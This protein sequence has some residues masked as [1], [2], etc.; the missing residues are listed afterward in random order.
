MSGTLAGPLR[1]LSHLYIRN[2]FY[3]LGIVVRFNTMTKKTRSLFVL[4]AFA[5][6]TL[7]TLATSPASPVKAAEPVESSAIYKITP[8]ESEAQPLGCVYNCPTLKTNTPTFAVQD[9]VANTVATA[10]EID[11]FNT[12]AWDQASQ[13]Q[14]TYQGGCAIVS[15]GLKCWGDNSRGQL[16]DETITS[17]LTTPVTATEG[18][19]ALSNVTDVSTN[20]LTTCVVAG[21]ALKCVGSGNWE[22]NYSKRHQMYSNTNTVTNGSTSRVNS[23]SQKLE[24]FNAANTLIYTKTDTNWIPDTLVSKNWTTFTAL[25]SNVAK[26][27]VGSGQNGSSTPT[28]CVLLTTGLA[29]CAVVTA[30]T[31]SQPTELN[32]SGTEYDCNAGSA[33]DGVYESTSWCNDAG[34]NFKSR[35]YGQ[36]GTLTG[37]ATWTWADAEVTGAVD[38]AMPADSW[39][40]S[41]ICFAGATT[42]CR[43]FQS[44]VFG[45][46]QTIENGENSQAVYMTSG[47]GP[48]G[49]CL[50]S[51]NTISCGAGTSGS[52]GVSAVAT[53]V[54]AVA[55]MAKPLNIFFGNTQLMQKLYFLLPTGLLAADAWILT[56]SGCQSQSG[57][58]VAPVTAFSASTSTAFTYAKSVNGATDSADYIPMTVMSG[59]RKSRSSVAISVKTAS[60]ENLTGVSVRWTAP[61]APGLLS[62]SASSTLA[63]DANGAA[64][65]TV[66]SGPVTF[67][68]SV[69]TVTVCPPVCMPGQQPSKET[70]PATPSTAGVLASGATLQAASITVIVG[71]TG[72]INI[73]VPDAPAIVARKIS[74]TLPDG[75]P[76]PN[77]TVQLK[78]NY[79]TYAYTNSG[80][81][82]S[83]W[84]S[85]PKDTNGYLGQMN[86]AYC[87]VAPPKYATGADGS[88]TFSS[89]N[90]ASRS[91]AYDA[92]VAYDDGELNQ[93][94][95]KTFTSITE[96]VTMPFMAAIKVTLPDADPATPAKEADADPST[97]GTDINVDATGGVTVVTDLV[98]ED[99]IPISD[100]SQSVETVN[101]GSSCEQGGLV[102]ATDK[103]TSIC[104]SGGVA[105]MS[106]NETSRIQ[107]MSVVSAKAKAGCKAM[108]TATTGSNGKATLKICPTV[109]TKY[110]IRAT[111]AIATQ[112]ICVRVN[113]VPCVTAAS[114]G[115]KSVTI[116][117]GKLATFAT[118]NKTARI[119]VPKGAKVALVVAAKSKKF[120][121]VSGTS[122]K[123]LSKGSCIVSVKVTPKATAKVKKPATTTTNITVLI[124]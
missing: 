22:G 47:W 70:A 51:N 102:A 11:T 26:V 48:P 19:T 18:G 43:T 118:I 107:A 55:V 49:L 68:L 91:S 80:T 105:A 119:D 61:D 64:R 103:V 83:T 20:G 31:A 66:T 53:K 36:S 116:K 56:C 23:N 62:S 104:A 7:V 115:K 101:A 24:I 97:P 81:S 4:F 32:F 35:D 29:K 113:K 54:T 92:D 117:K 86:C 85:R 30:G 67:T 52:N 34:G 45:A 15:A 38:I 94:V 87:F 28:I 50:Y 14:K 37:S 93:N 1:D 72:S 114:V 2:T 12:S 3:L 60:G 84:S 78:N 41:S 99:N 44:G 16:G 121:S 110:R 79:L 89:F 58:V 95:K 63:T 106:V 77:A 73:T 74:V 98:D 25:G 27:Q 100:F 59:D 90:P 108:M 10:T 17:S 111:G 21:G 39:G 120:C 122:V 109:S 46:K 13:A 96:T 112:T 9:S 33:G 82:T 42:I 5:A 8:V 124:P 123:A 71:E 75:T 57:S 6:G 76:V 65:T 40:A 88:V 69:P